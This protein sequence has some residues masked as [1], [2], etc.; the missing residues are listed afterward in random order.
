[1]FIDCVKQPIEQH[2]ID[3]A[4]HEDHRLKKSFPLNECLKHYLERGGT[5]IPIYR[6]VSGHLLGS[7]PVMDNDLFYPVCSGAQCRSQ[8]AYALLKI[9]YPMHRVMPPHAS[10]YGLDPYD[11]ELHT[12]FRVNDFE[13]F[14]AVFRQPKCMPFGNDEVNAE[15][16]TVEELKTYFDEHYYG[17]S[18]EGKRRVFITFTTPT[19]VVVK[20][21]LESNERVDDTVVVA[22]PLPDEI[23]VP[24]EEIESGSLEA[25]QRFVHLLLPLFCRPAL[26]TE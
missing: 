11:G 9:L 20:R 22:I 25:Y 14:E 8:V 24:P 15:D 18:F 7:I 23:T 13:A 12:I 3:P 21:L 5:L 16:F 19:H 10:R 4:V 26:V 17:K 2:L 1:M 6:D